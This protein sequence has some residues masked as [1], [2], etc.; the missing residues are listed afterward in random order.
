EG[1]GSDDSQSQRPRVDIYGNAIPAKAVDVVT[2]K[3][4]SRQVQ[5]GYFAPHLEKCLGKGRA[6]ARAA[7][8]R[9]RAM[10]QGDD[11]DY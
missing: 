7:S 3:N 11:S 1:L 2:C 8:M 5:A 10:A 4:C 6:A 9:L